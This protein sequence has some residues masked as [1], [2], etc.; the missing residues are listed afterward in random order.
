MIMTVKELIEKLKKYDEN[1][2]V[3]VEAQDSGGSYYQALPVYVR[4]AAYDEDK[5]TA[6]VK[7]NG[8][9]I[10]YHIEDYP[11]NMKFDN[12]VLL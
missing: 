8:E 6:V 11:K 9:K 3:M 10:H 2:E 12:I 4:K 7:Y 5:Q 1:A